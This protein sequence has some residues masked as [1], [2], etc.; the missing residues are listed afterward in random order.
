MAKPFKDLIPTE[1]GIF[2]SLTFG[3]F[4]GCRICD[5]LAEEYD[6]LIWLER[7]GHVKYNRYLSDRIRQEAGFEDDNLITMSEDGTYWLEDSV[8]YE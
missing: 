7:S 2:D 6:Y 3:K 5:I 1:L 8:L 4:I